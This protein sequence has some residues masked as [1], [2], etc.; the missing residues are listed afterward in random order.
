ML[1]EKFKKLDRKDRF[2]RRYF[3]PKARGKKK[4]AYAYELIGDFRFTGLNQY[5]KR[6]KVKDHTK[7]V[8]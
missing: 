1:E 6:K 2:V 5:K 4:H 7:A 8:K 3:D